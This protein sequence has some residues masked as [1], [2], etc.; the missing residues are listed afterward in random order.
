MQMHFLV[1]VQFTVQGVHVIL[2]NFL[3]WQHSI[4]DTSHDT[5]Q[6]TYAVWYKSYIDGKIA[7]D[8]Y[9]YR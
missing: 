1:I 6:Y 7:G 5:L 3:I 9:I 4:A 8:T 2:P